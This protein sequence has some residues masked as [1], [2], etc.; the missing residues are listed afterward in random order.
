MKKIS[1]ILSV[2]LSA[3]LI[4]VLC[5]QG[6]FAQ[7]TPDPVTVMCEISVKG[8]IK[9]YDTKLVVPDENGDSKITLDDVFYAAH[10]KYYSGGAAAGYASSLNAQYGTGLNKFWG[11]TS[12]NF[13][14]YQNDASAWNLDQSVSQGD[15]VVG[16]VYSDTANYSDEYTF[17]EKTQYS[18]TA[19]SGVKLRLMGITFDANYLPV[20]EGV[21]GAQITDGTNTY[22]TDADGYVTV[23]IASSGTFDISSVSTASKIIVPSK[24][25]LTLTHAAAA[26][27]ITAAP[28]TASAGKTSSGTSPDTADNTAAGGTAV[29]CLIFAAA[30]VLNSRKI[31]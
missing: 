12:K 11:D 29:L 14:Y 5:L 7:T 2:I 27:V 16:F 25:V 9:V 17:F 10:E 20:T 4:C 22:T 31:R 8:D 18:G 19:G 30:A 24:T 28:E 13:G 26:S 3:A 23:N 21:A 6:A 1:K 15:R